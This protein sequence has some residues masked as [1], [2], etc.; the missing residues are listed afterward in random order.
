[1][2]NFLEF[3]KEKIIDFIFYVGDNIYRILFWWVMGTTVINYI[4]GYQPS[5]FKLLVILLLF[6]ESN[7]P[8]KK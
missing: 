4:E 6:L 7:Q 5:N 8:L 2:K 1:M 3:M